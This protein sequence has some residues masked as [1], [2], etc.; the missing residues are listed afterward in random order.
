MLRFNLSM[1]M[2]HM[3][4]AFLPVA[5]K[6][7]AIMFILSTHDSEKSRLALLSVKLI[8]AESASQ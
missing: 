6:R 8:N 1:V 2:V 5:L 7:E 3:S 4:S